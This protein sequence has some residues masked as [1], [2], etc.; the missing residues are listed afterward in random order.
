MMAF[1]G[2]DV[3]I[4]ISIPTHHRSLTGL[5]MVSPVLI[6]IKNTKY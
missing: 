4:Y 3:F 2:L 1:Y 6:L 5:A